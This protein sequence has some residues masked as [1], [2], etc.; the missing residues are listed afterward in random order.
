MGYSDPGF[1]GG[2]IRTPTL[3]RLVSQGVL[4]PQ[5][6]NTA[7]CSPSRAALLT[8]QYAHTAGMGGNIA[9]RNAP[10]RPPGAYQ[11]VLSTATPT[12]A[13]VLGEAGYRT[14]MA[15]KW[16][17][18]EHEPH[19]PTRRGFDRYFGLI[20]GA[21]SY[22]ELITDQPRERI[23]ANDTTRWTPPENDF[24]MTDA[25]A[26]SASAFI[27]RHAR[28]QT[29]P[30][31]LYLPFTAPH[32]PLHADSS[33]I[34][35]YEGVYDEGWAAL[36]AQ[37]TARLIER[38]LLPEGLT[39]APQPADVPE[40]N[41]LAPN[42][43]AT[44]ARRMQ[45][46]AA[47]MT[48]MDAAVGRVMDTLAEHGLADN[49]LVLFLS[50]N[51]ASAEDVTNRGHNDASVPI[52]ARGSYDAFRKPWAWASVAPLHRYKLNLDEGGMRTPLV[53][54]WPDGLGTE[55]RVSATPGHL[56]D[57]LPTILDAS[58]ATYSASKAPDLPG[59]SL[60]DLWRSA[61]LPER[62]LFW[63]YNGHR[64]VRLGD[65]KA[66]Y[67]RNEQEWRLYNIAT[68]PA[69]TIDLAEAHPTRLDT[70]IAAWQAWA[71]S[72]GVFETP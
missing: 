25:F 14:Y 11:G 2:D 63:E 50:D 46:H 16:H 31:F 42:E 54:Y 39:P 19:W 65:F 27:D 9:G 71:G 64:A 20:S 24:Y 40:W 18:G 48:Q 56:I 61:S 53:A 8:G 12:I 62:P 5:F 60:F 52:G 45:V 35:S 6:Y 70:L 43:Q 13:E 49:T 28:T 67:R 37:R 30:F 59:T 17:V 72:V 58:N 29:A 26:D 33:V 21:S 10:P 22:Y 23:L 55:S 32:W 1:M 57:L 15:G 34:A 4:M 66:L 3:D 47:M 41:S 69:E 7:K 44:W 68:D 38:G 51:G 36:H